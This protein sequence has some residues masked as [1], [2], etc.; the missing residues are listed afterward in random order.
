MYFGFVRQ[1]THEEL[2]HDEIL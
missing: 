2:M 1:K